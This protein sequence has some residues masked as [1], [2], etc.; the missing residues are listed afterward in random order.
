MERFDDFYL[1]Q[2][3]F[4]RLVLDKSGGQVATGQ[5]ATLYRVNRGMVHLTCHDLEQPAILEAGAIVALRTGQ[6]HALQPLNGSVVLTRGTVPVDNLS[7]L[8]SY[9]SIIL[10]QAGNTDR[11]YGTLFRLIDLVEVELD[12]LRPGSHAILHRLA[13]LISIETACHSQVE[14]VSRR[15]SVSGSMDA[16]ISRALVAL[17]DRPS[18]AWTTED[19]AAIACMSRSV[20]VQHFKRAV[21]L[22]P[23]QYR[24]GLNLTRASML[25]RN[26]SMSLPDIASA[27]GF[28]T[29]S[30]LIKAFGKRFGTTPRKYR[31]LRQ[32]AN[33]SVVSNL[34]TGQYQNSPL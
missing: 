21:G 15:A 18:R 17:H 12:Q 8:S 23:Y 9:P 24:Q 3:R 2:V 10:F 16:R 25:L 27:V 19:L 6:A 26:T 28:A 1:S 20:F 14:F 29:S 11:A 7:P 32:R 30:S 34:A 31:L 4:D 33:S 13:E 5:R 22:P